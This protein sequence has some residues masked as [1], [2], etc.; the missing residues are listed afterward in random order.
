[1]QIIGHRGAIGHFPENTL[2]SFEKAIALGCHGVEL[3][4]HLSADKIPMVIHDPTTDRTTSVKANVSELTADK[5][6]TIPIEGNYLIPTLEDVFQLIDRRCFINVEIKEGA[7]LFPTIELINRFV[8]KGWQYTDFLISSFDWEALSEIRSRQPEIPLGVLTA[9][10]LDLAINFAEFIN[11]EAIH[12]Y[13][14]LLTKINCETMLGKGFKVY[15]W[16][17][18]EQSDILSIKNL[19]VTGIITDFPERI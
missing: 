6:K 11:A 10:D 3:D 19:N 5:L 18:N 8:S 9:T 13:Y 7:A 17:V 4:V 14:H 1:M 12:P 2:E 16:T 15:P